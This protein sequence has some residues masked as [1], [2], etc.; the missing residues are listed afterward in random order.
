MSKGTE[1]RPEQMEKQGDDCARSQHEF[2]G[3]RNKDL[4]ELKKEDNHVDKGHVDVLGGSIHAA[5]VSAGSA[6]GAANGGVERATGTA[7]S[8]TS[9]TASPQGP[10][11]EGEDL[12]S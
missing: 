9:S 6:Q 4:V 10:V 12:T 8:V 11:Q 1:A 3:D 2:V 7:S 5:Q